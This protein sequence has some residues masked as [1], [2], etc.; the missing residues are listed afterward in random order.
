MARFLN[1]H[2]IY[3]VGFLIEVLTLFSS[4]EKREKKIKIKNSNIFG[5]L[6]SYCASYADRHQP[7]EIG[8]ARPI[9]II[10]QKYIF[11]AIIHT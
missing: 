4:I 11:D 2:R 3:E 10:Y 1:N 5:Q 6:R 7:K 8:R 9:F